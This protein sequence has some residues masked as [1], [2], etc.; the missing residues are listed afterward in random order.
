MR[1]LFLSAAYLPHYGGIEV[2]IHDMC[3]ELRRRAHDVEIVTAVPTGPPEVDGVT[4]HR[5][6]VEPVLR[7]RDVRGLHRLTR[8]LNEIG[9]RFGADVVHS[10]DMG[11]LLWL[12]L[13]AFRATPPPLVVTVH[14]VMSHHVAEAAVPA[15]PMAD[16]VARADVVTAVSQ[17]ALDDTLGYA[18]SLRGR[19]ILVPNG[20]VPLPSA[21]STDRDPDQLLFV[22]RFAPQ[23]GLDVLVESMAAVVAARP[24]TRLVVVGSGPEAPAARRRVAEL[25]LGRAV[26]L[27]GA[28]DPGEVRRLMAASA[29]LVMP[30]RYEGLPLVALEAAFAGLPVVGTE[31]P[32]LSEA[33]L[34]GETGLLVPAEDPGAL[35]AAILG[36]LDDPRRAA[37]LG[38]AARSRA[39]A[40]YTLDRCVDA[41]ESLYRRL[42]TTAA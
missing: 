21:P 38:R 36:L 8:Q 24:T 14:N 2:L 42:A 20:V 32:G 6:D 37:A 12:Q 18:P 22:G 7:S 23:K 29:A 26:D 39:E 9:A 5:L 15:G 10:H 27:R 19:L 17:H 16:L 13:R 41:Y 33:V 35:A 4:V 34:D 3:E 30:S 25:G 31:V 28:V 11:A 1:I 40:T